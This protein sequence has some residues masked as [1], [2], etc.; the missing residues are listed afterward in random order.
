MSLIFSDQSQADDIRR[1]HRPFADPPGDVTAKTAFVYRVVA[2]QIILSELSQPGL[3]PGANRL[4]KCVGIEEKAVLFCQVEAIIPPLTR[5]FRP[6][7]RDPGGFF[8]E[9]VGHCTPA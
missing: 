9:G 3:D 8:A 7:A 4:A 5:S 1:Q 2:A 6:V